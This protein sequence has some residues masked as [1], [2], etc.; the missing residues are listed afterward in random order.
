MAKPCDRS[1]FCG[2]DNHT[3]MMPS[4][5]HEQVRC[6]QKAC[7]S[8]FDLERNGLV[9]LGAI[10]L[11]AIVLGAIVVSQGLPATKEKKVRIQ[12]AALGGHSRGPPAS[13]AIVTHVPFHWIVWID[14]AQRIGLE[15]R[16][17]AENL[18]VGSAFEGRLP[19]ERTGNDRLNNQ[20]DV[21]RACERRA[22]KAPSNGL[23]Y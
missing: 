19:R 10:V 21:C 20:S 11:G 9:R 22:S 12:W 7:F 6:R 13:Y 2:G 1:R 4:S 5:T 23:W 14:V 18:P 3:G 17:Q 8:N 15:R 16:S